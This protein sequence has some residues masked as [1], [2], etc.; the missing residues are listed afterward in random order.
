MNPIERKVRT[1]LI[2]EATGRVNTVTNKCRYPN[3]GQ[4]TLIESLHGFPEVL[5][6][7]KDF[8]RIPWKNKPILVG[9]MAIA[10]WARNRRTEDADFIFLSEYRLSKAKILIGASSKFKVLNGH[11]I[12]HKSTGVTLDLLTPEFINLPVKY[13]SYIYKTAEVDSGVRIASIEGLILMKLS[14]GRDYPDLADI[15]ML[16]ENPTVDLTRIEKIILPEHKRI[17]DKLKP[18]DSLMIDELVK[19]EL[20]GKN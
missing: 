7:I 1:K 8:S 3:I 20:S 6:A 2:N 9:G 14:S 10:Y 19:A 5:E 18:H 16:L 15:T 11:Y 13:L 4:R 12:E 17:L